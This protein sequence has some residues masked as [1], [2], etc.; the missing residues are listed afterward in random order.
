MEALKEEFS[1]HQDKID[2]YLSLLSD[3]ESGD[4]DKHESKHYLL[5]K[6]FLA[7]NYLRIINFIYIS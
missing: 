6:I 1:H 3:I 2:E 5:R 4:P 7:C